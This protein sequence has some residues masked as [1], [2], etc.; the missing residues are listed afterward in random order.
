MVDILVKP[1]GTWAVIAT[2]GMILE[3]VHVN[4][5]TLYS[6]DREQF[7]LVCQWAKYIIYIYV[8]KYMTLLYVYRY[9]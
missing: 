7:K 3:T 2:V 6:T 5:K 9:L 8:H 4:T 1:A